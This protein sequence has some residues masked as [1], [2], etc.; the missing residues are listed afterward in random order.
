M[1]DIK[2][3]EDIEL[4]ARE[5]GSII[6]GGCKENPPFIFLYEKG[7]NLNQIFDKINLNQNKE[8]RF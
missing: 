2:S 7:H 6:Y 4:L 5:I 3:I 1:V 8:M